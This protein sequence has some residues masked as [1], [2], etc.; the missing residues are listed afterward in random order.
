MEKKIKELNEILKR[1]LSEGDEGPDK[2]QAKAMKILEH[3][4][5]PRLRQYEEQERILQGRGSYSKTDQDATFMRMKDDLRRKAQPKAAYNIQIG[6]EGQFVVGM[7]VH[8]RPGDS[9]CLVPH[10][11]QLKT[12]LGRLPKKLIADA[13]YGSEEN[14]V[15]LEDEGVK[16]F[17]KYN[18]F[19][20]EQKK[21]R[22]KSRFL[23]EMF[24]YDEEK[25]EFLCPDG[26]RMLYHE[27]SRYR[28]E[29]GYWKE[30]RIY[31]CEDCSGCELKTQC[32]RAKG[33]R[34][35][36]ISFALQSLRTKARANLL[37]EEGMNVRSRRP[38]EAE[39]VFGRWKHN[40]NFRRFLLRGLEKV[41]TEMGLLSIAH[42]ITKL[43]VS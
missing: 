5:L 32:T 12:S 34:S 24:R 19:H 25:D 35:I 43:A 3:D 17:V 15:Y 13:G 42:N 23:V 14:Y 38:V 21:D 33:N 36:R 28:S 2:D 4:C 1:R 22:R 26:R 29:N 30:V 18:T 39:S 10:L 41:E 16:G 37:S 20:Q 8:Q 7:S 27:T 6:T 31:A 40:W 11:E 9:G